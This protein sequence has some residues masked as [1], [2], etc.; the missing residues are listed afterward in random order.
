MNLL[1]TLWGITAGA[2]LL[3]ILPVL[4]VAAFLPKEKRSVLLQKLKRKLI[5]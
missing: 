4:L 3:F 1:D 2:T 5:M